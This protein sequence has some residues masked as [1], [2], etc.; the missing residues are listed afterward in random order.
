MAP[1]GPPLR[2]LGKNGPQVPA[3]GFGLMGLAGAYGA[4]PS[5][6]E[7]FKVL[8]R[9]LE[10]GNTFWDTA[11]IYGF[12]DEMLNAWFKRTGKR[13]QIFLATKFG[14]LMERGTT[15][16]KGLNSSGAYC[17]KACEASLERMGIKTIDL[18]YAHRLN[19][20]T[21]IEETMR[22]MVELKAEGKI[23]Y[24]GICG[25]SSNALRRACKIAHVDA[26]QVEYSPFVRDIETEAGTDL[27][28]TCRELGIAVVAYAPLGRGL[29]TGSHKTN[30][31]LEEEDVRKK[32]MPWFRPENI[33]SNA[34]VV[35]Q[36]KC[37]ADKKNC[38]T[39]QLAIAWVVKQGKDIIPIPGTR[40]IKYLEQNWHSLDVHLSDE[41]EAEIRAFLEN[42]DIQG[43]NE[44]D[45]GKRLSFVDTKEESA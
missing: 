34:K 36:F 37:F 20:D 12:N 4:K 28:K 1:S 3:L 19:P 44:T 27:L 2:Q 21:P 14:I 26:V 31:S 9:A 29:L 5:E 15:D 23:R 13:D 35:E 6:E 8:D 42:A 24:I 45:A 43:S 7:Q 32:Y 39:A 22:A 10:L 25:A 41:E 18:Y 16:F 38:T 40:S 33:E 30:A 11:D 17:K